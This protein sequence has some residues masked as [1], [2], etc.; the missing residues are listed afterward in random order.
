MIPP[1]ERVVATIN[2]AF[3]DRVKEQFRGLVL[4]ID[5]D[6]NLKTLD[7]DLADFERGLSNLKVAH[8]RT[9]LIAAKIFEI[10]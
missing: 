9:R 6:G 5:F 7:R 4:Q 10:A 1:A 8:E 3:I 2:E